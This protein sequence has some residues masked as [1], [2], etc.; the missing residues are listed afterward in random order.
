MTDH[1]E[2]ELVYWTKFVNPIEKMNQ[3]IRHN[4]EI[5]MS[6]TQERDGYDDYED[7]SSSPNIEG[8]M[9]IPIM[10]DPFDGFNLWTGHFSVDITKPI[11]EDISKVRGVEAVDVVSRYRM[12]VA[13]GRLFVPNDVMNGIA[14]VVTK[15]HK[16]ACSGE[17]T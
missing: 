4:Q 17:T 7:E 12:H 15:Y 14:K 11:R 2:K 1:D 3:Q 10:H 9:M 13:V 6:D 5:A 16:H 8:G